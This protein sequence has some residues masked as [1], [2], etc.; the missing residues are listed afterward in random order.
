MEVFSWRCSKLSCRYSLEM[1]CDWSCFWMTSRFGGSSSVSDIVATGSSLSLSG[2]ARMGSSMSIYG[3][4]RSGDGVS[5]LDS[6]HMGSNLS[7]STV[8]RA[9]LSR[10]S[11]GVSQFGSSPSSALAAPFFPSEILLKSA[12]PLRVLR[13]SLSASTPVWDARWLATISP[14]WACYSADWTLHTNY[15]CLRLS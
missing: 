6:V 5:V 8:S 13:G 7:F 1:R 2:F 4:N 3:F 11:C 12:L 9:G 15:W 10:S 14:S